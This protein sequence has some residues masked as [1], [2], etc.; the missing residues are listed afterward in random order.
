[1]KRLTYLTAGDSTRSSHYA[2]GPGVKKDDLLQRLGLLEDKI[3]ELIVLTRTVR[4][5]ADS[6]DMDLIGKACDR[7]DDMM[8]EL[9]DEKPA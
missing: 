5:A 8:Q 6:A 1:M 7:I 3:A 9:A 4:S 2:H